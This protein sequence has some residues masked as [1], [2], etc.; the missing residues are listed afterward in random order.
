MKKLFLLLTICAFFVV[1][2]HKPVEANLLQLCE[3]I[4]YFK[5]FEW[6]AGCLEFADYG[7]FCG[8]G[9][10]GKPADEVDA[11]CMV[12]DHCYD[13]AMAKFPYCYPYVS[14]YHHETGVCREYPSVNSSQPN[15]AKYIDLQLS[16]EI[17]VPV[18]MTRTT[19]ATALCANVTERWLAAWSLKG[20][21][22]NTS[23]IDIW[24]TARP[25][26][27]NTY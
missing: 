7:C 20:I 19:L 1:Y 14:Y 4:D 15:P 9:G 21:M 2:Y 13:A 11:C 6:S 12:H 23:T 18:L 8:P 22:P 10:W 27:P 17:S 3:Q 5:K 24:D 16:P 26:E 25:M